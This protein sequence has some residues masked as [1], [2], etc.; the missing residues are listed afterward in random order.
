MGWLHFGSTSKCGEAIGGC[1]LGANNKLDYY[2]IPGK[3]Q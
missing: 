3:M 1:L 2:C